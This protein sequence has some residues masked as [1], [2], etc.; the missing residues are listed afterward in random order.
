[1][2]PRGRGGKEHGDGCQRGGGE[3]QDAGSTTCS[4]GRSEVGL[5]AREGLNHGHNVSEQGERVGAGT[6]TRG[7][8]DLPDAPRPSRVFPSRSPAHGPAV[9]VRLALSGSVGA[10]P[11]SDP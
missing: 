2:G 9:I 8:A 3:P 5:E 7:N 10:C 1:M 6:G 4:A 11:A